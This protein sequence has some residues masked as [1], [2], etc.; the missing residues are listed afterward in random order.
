MK[1]LSDVVMKKLEDDGR[2]YPDD[3]EDLARRWKVTPEALRAFERAYAPAANRD[4]CFTMAE[5]AAV[6]GLA[7]ELDGAVSS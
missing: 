1:K 7:A 6:H 4:R 5:A 3:I 2:L